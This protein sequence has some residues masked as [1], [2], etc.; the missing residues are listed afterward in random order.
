MDKY[1][2]QM[3]DGTYK[4][5]T[6][7]EEFNRTIGKLS[8]EHAYDDVDTLLEGIYGANSSV[9]KETQ[10]EAQL[11]RANRYLGYSDEQL[12]GI[13]KNV[14]QD[15][16][17]SMGL[18]PDDYTDNLEQGVLDAAQQFVDYINNA[19]YRIDT[20]VINSDSVAELDRN[21][22]EAAK[23]DSAWNKDGEKYQNALINYQQIHGDGVGRQEAMDLEQ[24]QR[25]KRQAE[26]ALA[27]SPTDEEINAAKI[28]WKEQN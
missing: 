14:K 4:L 26:E 17:E 27:N 3:E 8:I 6:A 25:D 12:K 16:I 1:F 23:Q 5:I 15:Y 21:A 18:D 2:I 22:E 7:A 13:D 11:R 9:D 20:T 24:A 28:E 10:R 19:E